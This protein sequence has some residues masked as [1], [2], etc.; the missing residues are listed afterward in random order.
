MALSFNGTNI[1]GSGNVIYNGT[2]CKTVAQ[3]GTQV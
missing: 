1:Q 3:N 2:Y